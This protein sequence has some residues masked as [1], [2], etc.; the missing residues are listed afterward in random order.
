MLGITAADSDR[1]AL[2]EGIDDSDLADGAGQVILE[3]L[4]SNFGNLSQMEILDVQDLK[5]AFEMVQVEA[6]GNGRLEACMKTLIKLLHLLGAGYYRNLLMEERDR[7]G[8]INYRFEAMMQLK[9][10]IQRGF[11]DGP[12]LGQS[13]S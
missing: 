6:D 10:R 12:G 13:N 3:F 9:E 1:A 4:N 2:L 7:V 11:P 8:R 5:K